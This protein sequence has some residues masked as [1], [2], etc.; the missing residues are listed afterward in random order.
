MKKLTDESQIPFPKISTAVET[1][2]KEIELM[3]KYLKSHAQISISQEISTALIKKLEAFKL[4]H[5]FLKEL[6]YD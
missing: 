3:E 5:T 1:L 4:A 6:G 2:Q